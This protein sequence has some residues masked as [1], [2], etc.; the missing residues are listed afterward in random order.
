MEEINKS[1][2]IS[3]LICLIIGLVLLFL[4]YRICRVG[5]YFKRTPVQ[6]L[7]VIVKKERKKEVEDKSKLLLNI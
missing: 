7:E 1:G 2:I 3:I 4:I 6:P 5:N